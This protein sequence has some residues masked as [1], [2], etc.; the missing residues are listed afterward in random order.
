MSLKLQKSFLFSFLMIIFTLF[1]FQSLASWWEK[2]TKQE[3]IKELKE[4]KISFE[5]HKNK[6]KLL[7]KERMKDYSL[8]KKAYK[9]ER[10]KKE[11][12]RRSYILKRP[13]K[14]VQK[15]ESKI[16]LKQ[17]K[18]EEKEKEKIRKLYI[19]KRN[20]YYN[21]KKKYSLPVEVL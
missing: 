2:A 20:E 17:K 6:R 13:K 16:I 21:L 3:I 12:L 10:D 8:Y 7:E 9:K 15:K 5:N 14:V 11:S 1:S 19:Q 18:E 4:K